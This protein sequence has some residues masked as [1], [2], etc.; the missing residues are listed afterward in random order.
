MFFNETKFWPFPETEL[1]F[2]V[3]LRSD[4]I[5]FVVYSSW[6]MSPE[7]KRAVCESREN[8]FARASLK[9][10]CSALIDMTPDFCTGF[11]GL[12]DIR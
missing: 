1:F 6:A 10:A 7:E 3:S 12:E 9:P 8:G 11:S 2:E 5:V 4:S